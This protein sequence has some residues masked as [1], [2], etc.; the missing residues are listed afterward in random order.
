MFTKYFLCKSSV[1]PGPPCRAKSARLRRVQN[2][3]LRAIAGPFILILTLIIAVLP[4]ALAQNG[5]QPSLERAA[6][7]IRD[8]RLQEADLE[9]DQ[10]LRTRP[11][12]A[13]A[14]NLRGAIR[15]QQ[16]RL[17]EAETLFRRA[18]RVDAQKPAVHLNLAHL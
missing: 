9:L 4:Q 6:G 7:L 12:D 16:G 8:N 5:P 18:A 15:A 11:N 10:I 3:T 17:N 2:G 14:L 13:D 1:P